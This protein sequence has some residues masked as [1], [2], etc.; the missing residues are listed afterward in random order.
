MTRLN[1]DSGSSGRSVLV[2]SAVMLGD[3]AGAFARS[4]SCRFIREAT[5]GTL[6]DARL[7]RYLE[8]EANFVAVAADAVR[9]CMTCPDLASR[10]DGLGVVLDDLMHSQLPLLSA[11][12]RKAG[13][14][15][16][17]GAFAAEPLGS[18]D[19]FGAIQRGD[20]SP[21]AWHMRIQVLPAGARA[22]VPS[23]AAAENLYWQWC[24]AASLC[25]PRR[26]RRNPALQEWIDMHASSEFA[27]SV[28]FWTGCVDALPRDISV[29]ELDRRCIAMLDA[30]AEFHDSVY[31]DARDGHSAGWKE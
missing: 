2:R 26:G 23:M 1:A 29:D 25:P 11:L 30:E 9:G 4:R 12:H 6:D 8:I 20:E 22:I 10:R 5:D 18:G 24:S 13:G 19:A 16:F 3:C 7:L 14:N 21:L 31:E 15:G 27:R 17:E 28:A